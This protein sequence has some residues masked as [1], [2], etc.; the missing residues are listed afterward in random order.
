MARPGRLLRAFYG[1]PLV[2]YRLGLAGREHW[3]GMHWILIVTRGRR[4]GR[5]HAVLLDLLGE[6][7]SRRRY[8]V[9]AAYGRQ[10]DWVRNIEAHPGFEAQVGT[11]RF[12]A[13]METVPE[14]EARAVMLAYV[15]AHS[16]YS[17]FIARMLGYP[18][19]TR[20]AKAVADW[21][22]EKFGM[23]AIVREEG[24]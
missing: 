4:S 6:D 20:D 21:L 10:A 12:A 3:I 17:P 15:R 16:F 19:P 5:E 23:L 7:P 22:V 13:R 1:A 18:G 14:E 8:Y 11:E 24:P 9:Q 2:A